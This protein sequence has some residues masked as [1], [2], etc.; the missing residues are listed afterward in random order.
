MKLIIVQLSDMHCGSYADSHTQKIEKAIAAIQVY[1]KMDKA[2]LVFSGDLTNAAQPNE[3]KAA[4]KVLGKFTSEL[5]KKLG[6]YI[7]TMIVP[8]NHDM[9]LPQGCRDVKEIEQWKNLDEHLDEEMLRLTDFFEYSA[10]KQCFQKNHL[11]D[12]R[13]IDVDGLKIQFCLLNS[14][15]FSTRDPEDKQLHY[16]PS[17]VEELLDRRE[18]ANLKITVMHHHYEWCKWDTKEMLKRAISTDDITFFGHDHKAESLTVENA[19]GTVQNIVMGG[20]FDLDVNQPASFNAIIYD[21][22]SCVIERIE[23]NWSIE[24]KVFVPISRGTVAK[25]RIGLIPSTTFLDKLLCDNQGLGQRFTDYYVLPKLSLEGEAFS[26]EETPDY[27]ELQ[28]MFE[29]LKVAKAIRITG[30]SGAGKSALLRYLYEECINWGYVPLL[31]EKRDYRDSHIEK[32]FKNL[33]E[34]QYAATSDDEYNA[35]QQFDDSR[36][37]IFID[38]IDLIDNAK[39]RENLFAYI[40]DSGKLLIYTTKEKSQDLEEAVKNRLQNKTINSI[41]ILPVYKETRDSII[42]KVGKVHQKS[43]TDIEAIKM[44][45]D[46]MVQSQTA[47]FSFTPGNMLQYIKYFLQTGVGNQRGGQTISMVFEANIRNSMLAHA[48]HTQANVFL[49]VLEYIANHMYFNLKAEKVTIAQFEEIVNSYNAIRRPPVNAKEFL[50]TCVKAR[51]LKEDDTSF[52]VGFYDKNIYAYFVAKALNRELEKDPSNLNKLIFVMDRICFGI[53][54]TIILFLS[55]IRSNVKIIL[56]IAEKAVE[57]MKQYPEWDFKEENIP[58][59]HEQYGM[60]NKLPSKKDQASAHKQMERTER[61]RHESIKFKGIFDYSDEDINK[62]RFLLMRALKYTQ[63]VGRALID[64]C[65]TLEMEELQKILQAIYSVPQKVIYGTLKEYQDNIEELVASLLAFA[66]ERL[67]E[68]KITESYIRKLLSHTGTIL[69]L[70]IM[71]DIAYNASNDSTI[72]ALRD[73]SE[74]NPNAKV[75]EL[76]MEENVGNTPNFVS[77]AIALHEEFDK[78][79]YAQMLISQIAR[80]HIIYTANIDGRQIDRLLSGKILS[81]KN[82]AALLLEQGTKGQS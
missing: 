18:E 36:K 6:C 26:S 32:M 27:I 50:Q 81:A 5:G 49:I 12:V 28:E 63:L 10:R 73:W 22:E 71:N 60:S 11:C 74:R 79:P 61:Q 62:T 33:F 29:A 82:K 55:F 39:A 64:Q 16:F 56:T 68:E 41:N 30:A 54:D 45:L 43:Q 66:K 37:I 70:N 24:G 72:T 69:A 4:R 76:M 51:I 65:A 17:Y 57:L 78:L 52:K 59:V 19:K 40:I 48:K 47:I 23:F 46:Y 42:E 13:T 35:Y 14:S 8:G 77:K 53:N 20:Q 25:K 7:P 34:E 2:V 21:T 3:Y 31:I 80:K 9:L 15:P 1:G 38:D 75:F 67:P 44:A 58:F